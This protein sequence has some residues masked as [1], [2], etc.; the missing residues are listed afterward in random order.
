[1]THLGLK[2]PLFV[3]IRELNRTF[4]HQSFSLPVICSCMS[5]DCNLLFQTF[6]TQDAVVIYPSRHYYMDTP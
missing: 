3:K 4:E 5:E 6:W 1:M 2:I